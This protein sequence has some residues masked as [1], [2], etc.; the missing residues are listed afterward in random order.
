MWSCDI[1]IFPEILNKPQSRQIA[2]IIGVIKAIQT[3]KNYYSL[4]VLYCSLYPLDEHTLAIS[5]DPV[6]T[7]NESLLN[8]R[9]QL[10]HN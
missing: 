6:R 2:I 7:V 5:S 3:S 8:G 1:S 10:R 9:Y 4:E